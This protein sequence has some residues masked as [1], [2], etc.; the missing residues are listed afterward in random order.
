MGRQ[1]LSPR[2]AHGVCES[3]SVCVC[4]RERERER[5][6]MGRQVLL[7]PRRTQGPIQYGK[8]GVDVSARVGGAETSAPLTRTCSRISSL[9]ASL[10]CTPATCGTSSPALSSS[11]SRFRL[12]R[13]D[14]VRLDRV[15]LDRVR[16]EHVNFNGNFPVILLGLDDWCV[17]AY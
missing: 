8:S 13:L 1:V 11:K 4:V 6:H 15:I 7:P 3:V 17:G 9:R 5:V 2:R 14:R 12:M 10:P 16:L